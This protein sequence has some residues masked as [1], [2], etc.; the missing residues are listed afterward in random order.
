M[1]KYFVF[2]PLLLFL[3]LFLGGGLY[4]HLIGTENA[5]YQISPTVCIL[6]SL[7]L[8]I[9][10]THQSYQKNIAH[11]IRGM[12]H[13]DIIT[14]CFIF[15]LAGAFGTLTQKLGGIDA[16][17]Y[18]TLKYVSPSYLLIGVF[19]LSAIVSTVIGTSM[20]VIALV[21]PIA[22]NLANQGAFSAALGVATVISGAMF[23]DNLSVVS[24]TTIAAIT[25]QRANPKKKFRLN[26]SIACVAALLAITLLVFSKTTTSVT[27][28]QEKHSLL[29]LLP[30]GFLFTSVIFFGLNVFAALLLGV[31][32]AALLAFFN[33]NYS[34]VE[35]SQCI[36]KGF[37]GTD[38]ILILSLFVGALSGLLQAQG[39]T[40]LL[41]SKIEKIIRKTGTNRRAEFLLAGLVSVFDILTAN[42]TLAIVLSGNIA[43]NIAQKFSVLPHRSAYLLDTFSCI[44]QGIL[45][46]GAQVLLASSLSG[47][48]IFDLVPKVYYCYLLLLVA[49]GEV[50]LRHSNFFQARLREK[51]WR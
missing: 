28:L 44:F 51:K 39:G 14:M 30:Y 34:I 20:G 27:L 29:K 6:P 25:S 46:Y 32:I 1:K 38:E 49:L 41:F 19:I 3:I 4:L 21:T 36:Y 7:I 45:P 23:G 15:L 8:G 5:F 9:F 33:Y 24:D 35:I 43:R 11:L 22:T 37:V 10:L 13:P 18:L 47:I 40:Q 2:A 42:N 50:F 48:P 16:I 26:A 31:F 17:V 12:S